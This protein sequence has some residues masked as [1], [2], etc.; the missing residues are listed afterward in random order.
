MDSKIIT[1]IRMGNVSNDIIIPVICDLYKK[2]QFPLEKIITYYKFEDILQAMDDCVSGK[3][4]KPV[5]L[6]D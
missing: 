5:L 6:F 2:G 4:I 3:G 1:F